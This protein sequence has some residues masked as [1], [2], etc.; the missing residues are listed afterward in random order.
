MRLL[1]LLGSWVFMTCA[2]ATE[3]RA[4]LLATVGGIL[5]TRFAV[6]SA[7]GDR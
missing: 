2:Y 4:A 6:E 5:A 1:Y 7:Y 3:W